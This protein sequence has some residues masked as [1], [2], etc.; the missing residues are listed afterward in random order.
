MFQL[1]IWGEGVSG[2]NDITVNLGG[3]RETVK[4]Y[5]VTVGKGTR[6]DPSERHERPPDDDGSC[7]DRRDPVKP[8]DHHSI[9]RAAR[10]QSRP[11]PRSQ[12]QTIFTT[13]T[14]HEYSR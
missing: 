1:A 4:I 2:K 7:H 5:D 10:A 8:F 13:V 11:L 14:M 6:S 12:Y 9:I 3:E